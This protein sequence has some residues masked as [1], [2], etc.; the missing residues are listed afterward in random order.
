MD[1]GEINELRFG[2]RHGWG[3]GCSASPTPG[4]SAGTALQYILIMDRENQKG[5]K[6]LT[7]TGN[8]SIE[9]FHQEKKKK[10]KMYPERRFEIHRLLGFEANLYLRPAE[11]HYCSINLQEVD[12]PLLGLLKA[13]G[14]PGWQ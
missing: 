4:T 9:P 3:K 7:S 11:S 6:A 13:L 14:A 5:E 1:G 2:F 8:Q 10:K 12:S